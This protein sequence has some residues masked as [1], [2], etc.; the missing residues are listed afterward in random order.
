MYSASGSTKSL[1][2][3]VGDAF[4]EISGMLGSCRACRKFSSESVLG[5]DK[6]HMHTRILFYLLWSSAIVVFNRY[7]LFVCL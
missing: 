6:L 1:Q 2:G 5:A 3:R 7:S 4:S